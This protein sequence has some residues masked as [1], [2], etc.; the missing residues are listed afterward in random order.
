MTTMHWRFAGH[1]TPHESD[2]PEGAHGETL[3]MHA[4]VR[5]AQHAHSG[6]PAENSSQGLPASKL[7]GPKSLEHA[8]TIATAVSTKA[9]RA[10]TATKLLRLMPMFL[11]C[12]APSRSDRCP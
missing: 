3:G 5:F 7:P 6:L 11:I 9:T 12:S 1:G 8:T 10:T 2:A 4:P